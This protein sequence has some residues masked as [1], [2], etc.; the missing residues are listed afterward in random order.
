[1]TIYK[2]LPLKFF[3]VIIYPDQTFR[4]VDKKTEFNKTDKELLLSFEPDILLIGSGVHGGGGNGFPY[5]DKSH[6]IYN[7]ENKKPVQ[8]IILNSREACIKYN[9]LLENNHRVLFVLHKTL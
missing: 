3:D 8:V 7:P 6:L 9:E 4:F 5:K 2:G 1:M